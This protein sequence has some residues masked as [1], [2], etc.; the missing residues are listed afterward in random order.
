MLTL[1][2]RLVRAEDAIGLRLAHDIT[3]VTKDFKGAILRRGH[4]IRAEDVELLKRTGHYYVLV[5]DEGEGDLVHEVEAVYEFAK[6]VAGQGTYVEGSGEGKALIKAST[7][8]ILVVKSDA[9]V[10]VNEQGDFVLIT[11]K[12]YTCVDK[13][14]V[15]GIVDLIPLFISLNTFRK[16]LENAKKYSP[17]I[18]VLKPRKSSISIVVTGTEIWEG[19]VKDEASIVVENKV[20][21]CGGSIVFKTIVPDDLGRIKS[22][23]LTALDC[24][25]I[26]IATGGMSIDPTDYTHKAIASISSEVVAYGIPIKPN[27][28][29]ML[30]Y[31]DG[32]AI[33]G[34][35]G[36][37]VYFREWNVLDLLLPKLM[38]GIPW[39]RNELLKLG[40]GGITDYFLLKKFSRR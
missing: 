19:R 28:M 15:V 24:S 18:N 30:A 32:K 31:R 14:E 26:V 16:R 9:L 33:I 11:R 34:V 40:E 8:G 21:K 13:G 20:K 35:P 36:S 27:T 17:I 1:S 10:K 22:A 12:G 23:L 7:N 4:R 2:P 3:M 37:I 25:D 38:L 6:I 5:E 29:T 39:T